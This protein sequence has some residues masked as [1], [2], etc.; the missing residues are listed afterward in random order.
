[1]VAQKS[2]TEAATQLGAGYLKAKSQSVFGDKSAQA[3]DQDLAVQRL[4]QGVEALDPGR[5]DNGV[6]NVREA[7]LRMKEQRKNKE[8]IDLLLVI[9]LE[10]RLAWINARLEE[11]DEQSEALN[12]TIDDLESGDLIVGEDGRLLNEEAERAVQEYEAKYGVVVDRNDPEAL[13]AVLEKVKEEQMALLAEEARA[14]ERYR[15]LTQETTVPETQQGRDIV[16]EGAI[17]P[18]GE[19]STQFAEASL[20]RDTEPVTQNLQTKPDILVDNGIGFNAPGL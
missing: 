9:Q 13:R 19:L 7:L 1:M 8:Y 18:R 5:I 17:G 11:L 6:G 15:E 12:D 10:Q 3:Y 14:Q 2:Y 20:G 16:A 4:M